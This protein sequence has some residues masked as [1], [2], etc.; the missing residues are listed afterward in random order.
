M[1]VVQTQQYSVTVTVD[2]IPLPGVFDKFDG[3]EI[4]SDAVIY[5]AGGMAD[6]EAL[7]GTPKVGDVTVS[8]GFRGERDGPLKKWLNGK[9]G[10]PIVIGKQ[11]LNPDRSPVAGALEVFSGVMKGVSTPSFDSGGND[12]STFDIVASISGL[13]S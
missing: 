3:G 5:M 12:V 2:G 11:P 6:P 8:R 10:R 9:V 4:D 13:P 7:P 1:S